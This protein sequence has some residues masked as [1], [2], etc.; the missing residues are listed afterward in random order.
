MDI[1]EQIQNIKFIDSKL[2]DILSQRKLGNI[3]QFIIEMK[4][5][6]Y[7]EE[8]HL[9]LLNRLMDMKKKLDVAQKDKEFI[10]EEL[11]FTKENFRKVQEEL[12]STNMELSNYKEHYILAI[13]QRND[14]I[15]QLQET[16]KMYNNI[17]S[18]F[19]CKITKP[20]RCAV[21]VLKNNFRT[22]RITNT[23]SKGIKCTSEHGVIYTIKIIKT[24]IQNRRNYKKYIDIV[25]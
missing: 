18:R 12:N 20:I 17:L 8:N 15:E 2:K 6:N 23:A 4:N 7:V 9:K 3:Y 13:S 5:T 22:N 25:S 21:E 11:E 16:L 14:L 10:K 24:K 1:S 19:L